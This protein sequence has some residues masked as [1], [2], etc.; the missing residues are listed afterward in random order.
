MGVLLKSV[1][2]DS[3]RGMNSERTI[4]FS[5]GLTLI[6]GQNGTGKTTILQAVEWCLTGE[7]P[8][9]DGPDFKAEDAIVN[10]F[11]D[12]KSAKVILTLEDTVSNRIMTVDR[13][14][15]LS[16]NSNTTKTN[17]KIKVK[18]DDKIFEDD[19]AIESL[20]NFLGS[21]LDELSKNTYIKQDAINQMLNEKPEERSRALDTIFGTDKIR[22][23]L[24]SIKVSTSRTR[25]SLIGQIDGIDLSRIQVATAL[26][27]EAGKTKGKLLARGVPEDTLNLDNAVELL[28]VIYQRIIDLASLMGASSPT[29][30]I[31]PVDPFE[32]DD[33][34]KQYLQ[35]VDEI[36][37]FRQ[38]KQSQKS[39]LRTNLTELI[40]S[41]NSLQD[42][43]QQY[44]NKD[45]SS[46]SNR[47]S[48]LE[49]TLKGIDNDRN[50]ISKEIKDL[51]K[52]LQEINNANITYEN[53]SNQL[54]Q[55]IKGDD[56]K[57]LKKEQEEFE[58]ELNLNQT[59]QTDTE[60]TENKIG[61]LYE[62]LNSQMISY[63][64]IV[65]EISSLEFE[66]VKK[67]GSNQ[68]DLIQ[69]SLNE[70][71]DKSKEANEH[72][73]KLEDIVSNLNKSSLIISTSNR[74]LERLQSEISKSVKKFGDSKGRTKLKEKKE[75]NLNELNNSLQSFNTY[76]SLVGNAIQYIQATQPQNCPVCEKPSEPNHL[77]TLL[78]SKVKI[79]ISKNI[80]NLTAKIDNERNYITELTKDT[81]Q[82][83]D[84]EKN[85]EEKKKIIT[86]ELSKIS[87]QIRISVNT[88]FDFERKQKELLVEIAS[89][90]KTSIKL[91]KQAS[92]L[93]IQL[94]A[95]K[96]QLEKKGKVEEDMHS[97][98]QN[99]NM[100][101]GSGNLESECDIILKGI[102]D[103]RK[104]SNDELIQQKNIE[105]DIFRNLT[106]IK[107]RIGEI[108]RVSTRLKS[109]G[110][111]LTQSLEVDPSTSEPIL[112]KMVNDSITKIRK[113]IKSETDKDKRFEE[114]KTS[115]TSE[116]DQ[117]RNDLKN[118]A[119][120]IESKS[121]DEKELQSLLNSNEV[122]Q[123]LLQKANDEL[124]VIE[125]DSEKY[126]TNGEFAKEISNIKKGIK[127][128]L[129]G[130][131]KY[132]LQEKKADEATKKE[133]LLTE[134]KKMLEK[135]LIALEVLEGSLHT[136][137]EATNLY[138]QDE[139][140]NIIRKH[141][142]EINSIYN[143]IVRHPVFQ[144]IEVDVK[145]DGPTIYSIKVS[146]SNREITTSASVRFSTA[147]LNSFAI[148]IMVA[149]SKK[150]GLNYSIIM[151][152]DPSQSMDEQHKQYLA[153][154]IN[155]L[156]KDK[157]LI[158]A[159]SD[160][161]FKSKLE[162]ECRENLQTIELKDWVRDGP[163]ITVRTV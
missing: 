161:G 73:S 22:E 146:D 63:R 126:S 160:I 44:S 15:K 45:V 155:D 69:N 115:N 123:K 105:K 159:T 151:M 16:K 121:K 4:M 150:A 28:S 97:F 51:T 116:A 17:T 77:L 106:S 5:Q 102:S 25:N 9:F 108:D 104:K 103:K 82:L 40:S 141:G 67:N 21:G 68:V 39:S 56:V 162:E 95:L 109:A 145:T 99:N 86:S 18:V 163:K 157:Q 118:I 34:L 35:S 120:L 81:I 27:E 111:A 117:I 59:L 61:K 153:E 42:G 2:I 80:K 92:T 125:I 132:L 96:R 62:K 23:F 31:I 100:N 139:V 43:L 11:S 54:N 130:H 91:E 70:M 152:D 88:D 14:R 89:A 98:L 71:R 87:S 156:I 143:R 131:V 83:L 78:N 133:H 30:R 79:D 124:K 135:N 122:D 12:K 20:S 147:Q 140:K 110:E 112:T 1:K 72:Q 52:N 149:N 13:F 94:N 119:K 58:E 128:L 36:D 134:K 37:I 142:D 90:K 10:C 6:S 26:Q 74:D 101:I 114:L 49:K 66:T 32:L 50:T 38:T 3:F 7:I 137:K 136:I 48:D 8:N 60:T 93:D 55:V 107:S 41:L 57:V 113:D 53:A 148:S 138:L 158:I 144:H 29:K 84:N 19:E 129:E 76:D 75:S 127:E 154:L 24:D 65:E 47:L 64:S 33:N 85:L 46:L